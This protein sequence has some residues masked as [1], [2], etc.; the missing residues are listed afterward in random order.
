MRERLTRAGEWTGDRGRRLFRRSPAMAVAGLVLAGLLF[1]TAGLSAAWLSYDVGIDLPERDAIGEM[2]QM[3]QATTIFDKD[4]NQVFTIFKEQRL[5]I[6]LKDVSP[7]VIKAVLSAEDQRFYDH[8]G[9]DFVRVLG[10]IVRN[11]REGRKAEGGS[12]V[13]QQLARASFLSTDK[14]YR[15]KLK[16][17]VLAAQIENTFTK[18]EILALYLNKVYFGDGLYG[19]EAAAR[20]YFAKP[21]KD[22]T[23]SEAALLVGLIKAPSRWAPTIDPERAIAR[24]NVV[25]DTMVRAGSIT[26][27]EY[28]AAKGEKLKLKDGLSIHESFGLYYKEQVRILLVEQ[29]G[30]ERVYQGGL[31]VYTALDQNMQKAAEQH[32]EEWLD[33][34]E[35]RP[36]Y[37]HEPRKAVLK[38]WSP[39]KGAPDYLQA[40]LM[41][42]D[43]RTGEVMALVGGRSFRESKFNR[44]VQAKRQ[45]GSAFKPFVYAAA[46]ERGASP[47]TIISNLDSPTAT[48]Q[49]A[50]VP[51]DEHSVGSS[52]TMRTALR[53]SSNRAAVQMINA[54]GV[55][56]AVEYA[57]KLEL[58]DM[59]AVPSLALGAGDVTLADM[60][61]A[62][63]AFANGGM[64]RDAVFIRK[65]IDAEGNTLF[66]WKDTPRKAIEEATA[67]FMA[68]MLTDVIDHGTAYG[69]RREGFTLPA[70]GKTGTTNDYKDGWFVGFTPSVVTGVWVGFDKPKTIFNGGY[71]AQVAVPIWARFMRDATRGAKPDWIERPKDIIG[72]AICRVSGKRATDGCRAGE[73]VYDSATGTVT[74]QSYVV[75]QYYRKGAAPSEYCDVHYGYHV[76]ASGVT[77]G[78]DGLPSGLP[79]PSA[80][81]GPPSGLPE[82]VPQPFPRAGD[83]ATGRAGT[84]PEEEKKPSIWRR[85]F[86]G[87][88]KTPEQIRA[89]EEEKA[90][91][92][93]RKRAERA[94]KKAQEDARKKAEQERKK[95]EEERKKDRRPPPPPPTCCD[96]AT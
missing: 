60:T 21:A 62:F 95:A 32:V 2:G 88:A 29:F 40:A 1:W 8:E 76:P 49:G 24:R 94:L 19:I 55:K 75:T 64:V 81:A 7:N 52:M 6:D 17:I 68:D 28:E 71:A 92:E 51:E 16:E 66:E 14:T 23:V 86:R 34:L 61:M 79:D 22:L 89:E 47:G 82:V 80:P 63:G 69:A 15:R 90:R 25:L 13:T 20:G 91:E 83:P 57:N 58:G 93:A 5:E 37:R 67:Y 85:I 41:A 50:W 87:N 9:V 4:D 48:P 30:W 72:V 44:A 36:G 96:P 45:A 77:S 74:Q 11:V 26:R 54:I 35:T 38:D 84:P 73:L 43:P 70:A 42:A 18:D 10:A 12:T 53:T 39:E 56:T 3:D 31:K 33:R 27:D 65:V 78:D 46:L 59:P